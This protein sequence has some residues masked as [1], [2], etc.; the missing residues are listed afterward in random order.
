MMRTLPIL[1]VLAACGITKNAVEKGGADSGV[2]PGDRA[3]WASIVADNVSG[4]ML[5]SAWNDGEKLRMVGGN[6]N[7]EK[8]LLGSY[9][10]DTLCTESDVTDGVLWWIDGDATGW[11]AVGSQ[12]VVLHEE[13][14]VRTHEDLPTTATLFGVWVDGDVVWAVGGDI[15]TQEGEIWRR[16]GGNWTLFQDGF[17]GLLFK[18]WDGWI[19]GDGQAYFWD[20]TTLEDRSPSDRVRLLTVRGNNTDEVWAVGGLASPVVRH[21]VNGAWETPVL[22]SPCAQYPLS[23]VHVDGDEVWIAGHSGTLSHLESETWTCDFPP[24]T[25]EHFHGVFPFGDEIIWLGGNLLSTSDSYGT[26]AAHP[27]RSPIAEVSE[28]P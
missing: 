17:P 22:E 10:G 5:L 11:Y 19:V 2:Y 18:I 16:E 6:L 23:G 8:G 21:W 20:G 15:A 14:G 26:V 4:G 27:A 3:S 13:A 24:I 9:D 28:C 7:N 12:G 25:P 1:W